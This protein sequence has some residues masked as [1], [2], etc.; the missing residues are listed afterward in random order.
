MFWRSG[1]A[2]IASTAAQLTG[3]FKVRSLY[4]FP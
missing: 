1:T 3:C 4:Y 2:Q